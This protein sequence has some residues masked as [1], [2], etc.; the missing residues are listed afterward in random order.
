MNSLFRELKDLFWEDSSVLRLYFLAYFL[1]GM[2]L[3][4]FFVY[5]PLFLPLMGFDSI[6]GVSLLVGIPACSTL[7]GQNFWGALCLKG[8]RFKLLLLLGSIS[9]AP[10]YLF[11]ALSTNTQ[12]LFLYLAVHGFL[13]G[14][15]YPSTQTLGT[16]VQSEK[17]GEI[18]GKFLTYESAGWGLACLCMGLLTGIYAPSIEVYSRVFLALSL[19]NGLIVFYLFLSF[20]SKIQ[21]L[22]WTRIQSR[23]KTAYKRLLQSPPVLCLFVYI[24]LVET[25]GTMFF[26]FFSR[27]FTGILGGS[28]EVLGYAMTV[29]TILGIL[30][31][32]IVGR[33]SD[34]RGYFSVLVFSAIS[35]FFVFSLVNLTSNPILVI[36]IY[37]MPIYPLISVSANAGI[38]SITSESERAIGFGLLESVFHGATLLSPLFGGI[39]LSKIGLENLPLAT[40][41]FV[42]LGICFLPVMKF[43]QDRNQENPLIKSV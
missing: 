39:F 8:D 29:C 25:G 11:L 20:P 31:L 37:A 12:I 24:L 30:S 7:I 9:F 40:L 23:G 15:F 42:S 2:N 4:I 14:A 33:V 26:F 6:S 13:L 19:I 3:A 36:M 34:K 10:L 32:P 21:G 27:Y 35:Y 38:A 22:D 1:L 18:I 43:F 28:E 41:V 16:L 17:K 5:C